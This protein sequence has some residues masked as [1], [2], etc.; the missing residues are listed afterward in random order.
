[1]IK[2]QTPVMI[3]PNKIRIIQVVLFLMEDKSSLMSLML[4]SATATRVFK[5]TMSALQLESSS[6][7]FV[8][9]CSNH[10]TPKI[11]RELN[12]SALLS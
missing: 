2:L 6:S 5:S 9:R 7:T 3:K 8:M 4:D 10:Y 11:K 12:K 1:M